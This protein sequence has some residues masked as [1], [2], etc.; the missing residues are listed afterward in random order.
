LYLNIAQTLAVFNIAAS[1]TVLRD[2]DPESMFLPGVVSHPA[3]F[4][5]SI[6]PRSAKHEALIRSIE[7]SHPWEES[8]AELLGSVKYSGY[9]QVL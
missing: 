9:L 8:D 7:K 4:K 6:K 2:L 5:A 1:E 3:A